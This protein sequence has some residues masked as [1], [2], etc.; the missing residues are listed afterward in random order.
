MFPTENRHSYTSSASFFSETW[1]SGPLRQPRCSL[2]KREKVGSSQQQKEPERH[3][4]KVGV[5][6]VG[7]CPLLFLRS[8]S[9]LLLWGAHHGVAPLIPSRACE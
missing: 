6:D 7:I 8:F 4:S 9:S 5:A 2:L 3:L 1:L